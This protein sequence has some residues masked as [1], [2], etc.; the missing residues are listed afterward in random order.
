MVAARPFVF[1]GCIELR[2]IPGHRARDERELLEKLEQV[3][4]GSVYYHTH[5]VFLRHPQLARAYPNDFANWVAT[6]I[7]DQVLA[8]R[9][10]IV[11]PFHFSSLEELR[12]EL[13]SVIDDHISTLHPVPRVVFGDPFFF[14]QSHLLEI[15]TGLEARTLEEFRR[16]L[17]AVDASAIYLH[18]LDARARRGLEG[19]DFAHWIG[20]ELKLPALA[21]EVS[22]ISPYL[23]GLEQMRRQSLRLLDAELDRGAHAGER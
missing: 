1:S 19:G 8:E 2:E 7:R 23:G 11:D 15:S 16:C 4:V 6:H 9:L 14:V 17:A 20:D 3:P 22:R 13:I 18:V 5:G 12:E 21:E 10:S